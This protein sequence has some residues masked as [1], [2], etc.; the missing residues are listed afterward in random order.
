LPAI[1]VGARLTAIRGATGIATTLATDFPA[2]SRNL[3]GES[4]RTLAE[5]VLPGPPTGSHAPSSR[6]WTVTFVP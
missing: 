3:V 1:P 6:I 5:T 2:S 4:S